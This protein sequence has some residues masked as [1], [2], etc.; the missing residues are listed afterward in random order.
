MSIRRLPLINTTGL[1]TSYHYSRLSAMIVVAAIFM[2]VTPAMKTLGFGLGIY[3]T[4]S[5]P[6]LRI[7]PK[8]ILLLS[9]NGRVIR[10]I[11]SKFLCSTANAKNNLLP[12]C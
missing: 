10:Y 12:N 4:F 7:S 1:F 5:I 3:S 9:N 6:R 2:K 8:L 11:K